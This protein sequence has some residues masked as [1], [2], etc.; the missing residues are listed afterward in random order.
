MAP[1][2]KPSLPPADTGAKKHKRKA[3]KPQQAVY[4]QEVAEAHAA[5]VSACA[6]PA[7]QSL[8]VPAS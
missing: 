5:L 4:L 1:K 6:L 2:R 8:H 7:S 3:G